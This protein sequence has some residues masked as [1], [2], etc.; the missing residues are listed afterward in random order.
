MGISWLEAQ[1]ALALRHLPRQSAARRL[2][3]TGL[4][5][6]AAKLAPAVLALEQIG[7]TAPAPLSLAALAA[8]ATTLWGSYLLALP[9]TAA[10]LEPRREVAL[11]QITRE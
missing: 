2:D 9:R 7:Q 8:L 11:R 3:A 4:A 1:R 10:L 6:A 5:A